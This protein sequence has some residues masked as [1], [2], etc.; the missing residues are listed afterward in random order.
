MIRHKKDPLNKQQ[1]KL[2]EAAFVHPKP[3]N[4]EYPTDI[5]R[6]WVFRRTLSLGWTPKLFGRQD[7]SMG[8]GVAAGR[9]TRP[10]AGE[11][12]TSGWP[13]TSC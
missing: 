9:G 1:R 8:Y 6:R 11:R 10:N 2:Y 4:D 3:V 5:A 12:S 7:R 13:T